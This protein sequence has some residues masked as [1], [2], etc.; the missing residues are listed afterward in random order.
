MDDFRNGFKHTQWN[1]SSPV[2]QHSLSSLFDSPY[3]HQDQDPTIPDLPS[4]QNRVSNVSLTL[5]LFL[6]FDDGSF[7]L[8]SPVGEKEQRD[9]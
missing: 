6:L 3:H 8:L 9:G 2:L 1:L 7:A 4:R 5:L